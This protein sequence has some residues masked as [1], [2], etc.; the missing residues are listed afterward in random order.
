MT[1][2]DDTLHHGIVI[3][4]P[5]TRSLASY[6]HEVQ[7]AK[8]TGKHCFYRIRGNPLIPYGAPCYHVHD[9]YVRGTLPMLG[10]ETVGENV[11]EDPTTGNYWPA[12]AYLVRSPEWTPIKM[13]WDDRQVWHMQGFRGWRYFDV[14]PEYV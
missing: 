7:K 6:L 1:E 8:D 5:K 2:H 4:W 9:G 13:S 11:V 14:V 3:T 10:V 12:G